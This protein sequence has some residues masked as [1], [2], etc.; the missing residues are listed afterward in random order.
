VQKLHVRTEEKSRDGWK[1][2]QITE[3]GEVEG[4]SMSLYES[5][6]S[7]KEALS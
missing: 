5:L 1:K 4:D 2:Y 6:I 3:M 7:L